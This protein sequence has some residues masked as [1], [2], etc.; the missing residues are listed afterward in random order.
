[1]KNVKGLFE[2]FKEPLDASK[3]LLDAFKE[4]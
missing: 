2:A 4:L 1:M 3:G